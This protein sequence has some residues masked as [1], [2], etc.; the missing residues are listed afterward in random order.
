M[1]KNY[2]DYGTRLKALW[3][4]RPHRDF[5]KLPFYMIGKTMDRTQVSEETYQDQIEL[6]VE[7][8]TS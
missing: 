6:R 3:T 4:V 2:V 1:A 5:E 8:I 7:D